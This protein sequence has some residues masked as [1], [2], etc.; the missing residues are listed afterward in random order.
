MKVVLFA[1]TGFGNKAIQALNS[2]GCNIV[3]LFTRHEPGPYPYYDEKNISGVAAEQSIPVYED[4]D[5]ETTKAVIEKC[6]PDLLLVS[7]F[8]KIIPKN[9][10]SKSKVAINIHPGLLPKYA[11]RNPIRAVLKSDERVTGV[12]A[13]YLTEEVDGGEVIIEKKVGLLDDDT[14]STLRKLLSEEAADVIKEII[15]MDEDK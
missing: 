12:T 4:V 6:S 15:K 5:W 14:E 11:G 2:C 9:I 8:H 10:I 7:T 3:A 13:H 1:L